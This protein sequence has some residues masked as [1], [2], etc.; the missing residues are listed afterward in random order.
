MMSPLEHYDQVF[1]ICNTSK[2]DRKL[3]QHFEQPTQMSAECYTRN[4]FKVLDLTNADNTVN[5]VKFAIYFTAFGKAIP[6]DLKTIGGFDI[7]KVTSNLA[8]KLFLFL[9]NN[10]KDL[11]FIYY[12]IGIVNN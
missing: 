4:I 8:E 1:K 6:F 11:L 9:K 5:T 3:I 7:D 12:N 10:K 2:L